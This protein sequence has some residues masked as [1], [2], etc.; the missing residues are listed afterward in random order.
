MELPFRL[1]TGDVLD[2][3]R[4]LPSASVHCCVTSP[5]YWGLR[6][7]GV[8]G[9]IGLEPTPDAWCVKLVDVFREVRRVLRPDGTLWLNAGDAYAQG[10]RG[11]IGDASTLDGSRNNQDESRKALM[12]GAAGRRPP[13]GL[14]HKDLIGQPWMLA[15]ALRA[16]GWYLR[17]DIIWSKPNPMPESVLDRP[18]KSHEYLFL[19]AKSERYFYD[20][21]AIR[22][23][24]RLESVL[25]RQYGDGPG[26]VSVRRGSHKPNARKGQETQNSSAATYSNNPSGRNRRSVWEITTASFDDAHFATFPEKLVEPCIMAGTSEAGCCCNCGAPLARV[27]ERGEQDKELVR[28]AGANADGTYHGKAKKNY[29]A[30]KA[31]DASAVKARILRGMVK[32]TTTGWA[33]TCGEIIA[34]QECLGTGEVPKASA[35]PL[36]EFEF[37]S[38]LACLGRGQWHVGCSDIPTVPCTVLDPFSGSG[39]TGAVALRLGRRYVGIEINPGYQERIA[40]PR[41]EAIAGQGQLAF[42]AGGGEP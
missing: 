42:Y 23:P 37:S 28:S 41:L 25:R 36:S 35:V 5:P 1:L 34:C 20:H 7:Y 14:K 22:E 27:I 39:T 26:G 18:T 17:S 33:P 2:Q 8:D 19:M 24:Y 9:Q 31:Q 32:K 6:D 13:P 16:D 3:L 11:G 12:A 21:D 10:G 30:G 38:C 29:A 15:F 4:T 40:R